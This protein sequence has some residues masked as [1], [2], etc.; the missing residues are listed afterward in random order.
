MLKTELLG[1]EAA[2]WARQAVEVR[3]DS[4]AEMKVTDGGNPLEW[5]ANK[6]QYYA[7]SAKC[8]YTEF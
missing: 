4:R 6:Q 7:A 2:T 3:K 1:G 8:F 5:K